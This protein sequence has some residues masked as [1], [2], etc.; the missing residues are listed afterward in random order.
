MKPTSIRPITV[1]VVIP[2]I[3]RQSV[4]RAI[5]SVCSQIGGMLNEVVVCFDNT[6]NTTIPDHDHVRNGV[7]VRVVHNRGQ[8]GVASALNCAIAESTGTLIAW[9]SDDDYYATPIRL[10][11]TINV[12]NRDG[13]HDQQDGLFF[14]GD[15]LIQD[16][17]IPL[18]RDE[19]FGQVNPYEHCLGA[20]IESLESH[21]EFGQRCV[22]KGLIGGCTTMFSKALW[23]QVGGF[24]VHKGLQTIQDTVFW[25]YIAQKSLITSYIKGADTCSVQHEQQGQRT[26]SDIVVV[27]LDRLKTVVHLANTRD[28][29]V[30]KFTLKG[31]FN[32]FY[33]CT[34]LSVCP[35]SV[36][37][38]PVDNPVRQ[39]SEFEFENNA[40]AVLCRV[41]GLKDGQECLS[42]WNACVAVVR[43]ALG[44]GD[45]CPRFFD[46]ILHFYIVSDSGVMRLRVAE[47]EV[48]VEFVDCP[49]YARLGDTLLDY[50]YILTG[51]LREM[52]DGRSVVHENLETLL[53]REDLYE[54]WSFLDQRDMYVASTNK[55]I[56][57]A[58]W[59]FTQKP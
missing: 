33:H 55:L 25:M 16:D 17:S 47:G 37:T 59:S 58:P 46:A 28:F 3:G 23:S 10:L 21:F 54:Y 38:L 42:A 26:E 24:P 52:V 32:F 12:I 7:K 57:R 2:T 36:Y 49:E 19:R 41:H 40:I 9:L 53:L 31:Q 27:E 34:L 1:S 6:E 44:A 56:V 8:K 50:R 14:F 43:E 29:Q 22:S 11:R 39:L 48:A 30:K 5:D 13:L 51:E 4:I 18:N 35:V 45:Y 15:F 20:H